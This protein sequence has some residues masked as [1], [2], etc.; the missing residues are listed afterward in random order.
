MNFWPKFKNSEE[1]KNL[2]NIKLVYKY[3]ASIFDSVYNG[4]IDT[5]DYQWNACVWF[6][7]GLCITPNKNL[8]TNIGFGLMLLIQK[9]LMINI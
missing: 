4:K 5:W 7:K 1:F 9:I 8:V 3:Y 2:F 6:N